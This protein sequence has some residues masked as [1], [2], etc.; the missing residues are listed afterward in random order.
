MPR[1]SLKTRLRHPLVW[2]IL[3]MPLLFILCIV[4]P[5][6]GSAAYVRQGVLI[7]RVTSPPASGAARYAA[8][9]YTVDCG[10]TCGFD[11]RVKLTKSPSLGHDD[12]E[13][14]F[15]S[16]IL[17]WLVYVGMAIIYATARHLPLDRAVACP[18]ADSA[19][20]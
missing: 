2:L 1:S 17:P 19:M 16:T 20:A 10:A 6:V 3:A 18:Q 15:E 5:C 12:Y 8:D 13:T 9:V 7:T 4:L 14:I 11:A